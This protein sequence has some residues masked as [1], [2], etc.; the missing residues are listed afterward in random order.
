MQGKAAR[1]VPLVLV[2]L[3]V[4]FA[5]LT[6]M[7]FAKSNDLEAALT[8]AQANTTKAQQDAQALR[9]KGEDALKAANAK[10]AALEQERADVEKMKV[11]LG[12]VEPHLAPVLE[13]A[14]RAKGAK[15]DARAAGLA[16]LGLIG[17][18]AH[19]QKHDASLATLERALAI[20]SANCPASLA[21]NLSGAKKLDVTPECAALLPAA[22]AAKDAKPAAEAKPAADAK[23]A[24]D[25][26]P[27]APA[28]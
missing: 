1:I 22:P 7:F 8:D 15:P 16:G 12:A 17:Q 6:A 11:L 26:K 21:I 20:D 10:I 2:F 18:I 27:A 25:A 13:A 3:V 19:G 4:V 24:P 23:P 14:S 5:A 9:K 28:K